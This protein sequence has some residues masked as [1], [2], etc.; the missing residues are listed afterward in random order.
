MAVNILKSKRFFLAASIWLAPA[1]ASANAPIGSES[2][3]SES[4]E[5]IIQ[6]P[7]QDEEPAPGE[8][9][10]S[11]DPRSRVDLDFGYISA[12]AS[13]G[14]DSEFGAQAR[15]L[16][17]GGSGR[18][19]G[20]LDYKIEAN[21]SGE[22]VIVIDAYASYSSGNFKFTGGLFRNFKGI[23]ELSS[24]LNTSFIERASFTDAFVFERR[25]GVSIE[26][27]KGPL[28][29]QAGVFSDNY[30]DL[31]S[32]DR[33]IDGR[34]V[35]APKVGS[36]QFHLGGSVHFNDLG[37]D[38]SLRYRQRPLVNWTDNRF[39]DTGSFSATSELGVGLEAAAVNGPFHVTLEG[40]SQ[41]V[42]RPGQLEDPQFYG[43][44]AEVGM[45]LTKGDTRAYKRGVFG[46]VKPRKAINKGGH[47]A[48]QVN[49][50]YDYLDLSSGAIQ[51]GTQDSLQASLIW[52]ATNNVRFLL[53]YGLV[54]YEGANF[55]RAD[56]DT[57]YSAHVIAVRGQFV[58]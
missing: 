23:E 51:G 14:A 21:F 52:K 5:P 40:Y 56:G 20:A 7:A 1:M 54:A 3:P 53:N 15:R 34:L 57:S 50:R 45:F 28:L 39:L 4:Q 22:E 10:W 32:G 13:T 25:L 6:L 35:Y 19:A 30:E 41:R 26:Y 43:A 37:D 36:T 33:S 42:G 46:P 9:R 18:L 12:P 17:L 49:L 11:F 55:P 48:L 31:S 38:R 58:F 27:A 29:V 2:E 16:R 44:S 24:T 47:G 8:D